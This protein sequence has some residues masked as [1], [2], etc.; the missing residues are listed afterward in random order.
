MV[1]FVSILSYSVMP[2]LNFIQSQHAYMK[3]F[4]FCFLLFQHLVRSCDLWKVRKLSKSG[5]LT[6]K[7]YVI[8]YFHVYQQTVNCSK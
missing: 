5:E 1:V 7:L 2:L 6:Q 3:L 4:V 8:S